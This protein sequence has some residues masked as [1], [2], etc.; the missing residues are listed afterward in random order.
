MDEYEVDNYSYYSGMDPYEVDNYDYYTDFNW[1]DFYNDITSGLDLSG[2]DTSWLDQFAT[3]SGTVNSAINFLKSIGGSAANSILNN[4]KKPESEGGG[5]DWAKIGALGGGL[6][7]LMRLNDPEIQKVGYQ[8]GIPTYKAVQEQVPMAAF[9]PNRRPGSGGQRYFSQ[10]AYAKPGEEEAKR[11][12]ALAE[13]A[14]LNRPPA[15]APAPAPAAPVETQ[16]LNVGGIAGL[17]KG[18]K[19][20]NP[21][22]YLRGGTDGMKDEV[23]ANIEGKQPAKLSHGEFVIPADVV[24]HLGNGNSEAGAKKLYNMMDRIR[25]A[26]TGTKQQGKQINPDKFM[27]KM[28]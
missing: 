17:A 20:A 9:D 13:I 8:G 3:E 21:P 23:A 1:D 11:A 19:P 27:P 4:F 6:A 28:G 26:R 12:A 24:S 2:S 7:G 22:R 25:M 18:G 5:Y 10:L 14:T 16:N 15:P